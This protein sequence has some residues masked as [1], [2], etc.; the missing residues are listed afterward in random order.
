MAITYYS[1]SKDDMMH[2]YK[3]DSD[4]NKF[5]Y[6]DHC[7]TGMGKWYERDGPFPPEFDIVEISKERAT[8]ISKD[9]L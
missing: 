8:E 4:T 1:R 2:L 3:Y 7:W 6:M 9:T 5:Y